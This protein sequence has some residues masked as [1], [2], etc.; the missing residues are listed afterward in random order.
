MLDLAPPSCAA[1]RPTSR[2]RARILPLVLWT[3]LRI[4]NPVDVLTYPSQLHR[5]PGGEQDKPDPAGKPEPYVER[6]SAGQRIGQR[7]GYLIPRHEKHSADQH[8][9]FDRML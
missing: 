5:L 8:R 4:P 6:M 3:S 1:R 9:V 7:G 2:H